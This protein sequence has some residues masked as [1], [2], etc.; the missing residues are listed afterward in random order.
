MNILRENI[1]REQAYEAFAHVIHAVQRFEYKPKEELSWG[2][3]INNF[4]AMVLRFMRHYGDP[5][6]GFDEMLALYI[7][8]AERIQKNA[9]DDDENIEQKILR[10]I[11]PVVSGLIT[12][13]AQRRYSALT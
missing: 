6:E 2:M 7:E 9:D 3:A 4:G 8:M 11:H 10:I 5:V 1:T 12:D 13:D